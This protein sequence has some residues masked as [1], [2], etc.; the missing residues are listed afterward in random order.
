M[1]VKSLFIAARV[2][3]ADVFALRA[4]KHLAF[5]AAHI[6]EDIKVR[7]THHTLPTDH[8]YAHLLKLAKRD[9]LV[10]LHVV[11]AFNRN[12]SI[13]HDKC[14]ASNLLLCQKRM[15]A[16]TTA[17][18]RRVR[19]TAIAVIAADY[20]KLRELQLP[21]GVKFGGCCLREPM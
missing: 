10:K 13:C 20:P 5:V 2:K 9:M 19:L 17:R 1:Q 7:K 11:T 4:E 18:N 15:K 16:K 6:H 21:P 12:L 3:L 14:I 8:K